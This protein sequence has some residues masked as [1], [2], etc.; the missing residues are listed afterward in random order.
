M[1]G[2]ILRLRGGDVGMIAGHDQL[3]AWESWTVGVLVSAGAVFPECRQ[4]CA[5]SSGTPAGAV[6]RNGYEQILI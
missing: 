4:S 2:C 5:E 3:G 6:A 1:M